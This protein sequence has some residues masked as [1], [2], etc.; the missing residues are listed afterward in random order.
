MAKPTASDKAPELPAAPL[1]S[2]DMLGKLAEWRQISD[3]MEQAKAREMALRK[4]LVSFLSPNGSEGSVKF[5]G[6]GFVIAVTHKL[7]RS[8]DAAALESVMMQLPEDVRMGKLISYKPEFSTKVYRDLAPDHRKIFE[9]ALVIK[10]GAPA[11]EIIT[12]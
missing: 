1:M 9:Q 11:L 7:T 8:L 10:E 4:E 12:L 2:P 3:W 6:P 5:Q